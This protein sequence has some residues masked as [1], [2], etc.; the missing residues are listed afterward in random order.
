MG[1]IESLILKLISSL[2][3]PGVLV[4]HLWHTTSKTIP[5][6]D[7]AHKAEMTAVIDKF[8]CRV[9]ALTEKFTGTIEKIAKNFSDTLEVERDYRQQEVDSLKTWIKN[10]SACRYNQDH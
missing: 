7:A 6:K 5:D 4:W 2:G 1:E 9:D 3:V 8:D 10:E